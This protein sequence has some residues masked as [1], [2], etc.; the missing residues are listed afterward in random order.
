MPLLD[1]LTSWCGFLKCF[2]IQMTILRKKCLRKRMW[3]RVLNHMQPKTSM[4]M[5]KLL[6]HLTSL[7]P[8]SACEQP[9]LTVWFASPVCVR[10]LW[11]TAPRVGAEMLWSP[12]GEERGEARV[13]QYPVSQRSEHLRPG[14]RCR[15]RRPAIPGT[16]RWIWR[17]S[18]T[19]RGCWGCSSGKCSHCWTAYWLSWFAPSGTSV[20]QRTWLQKLTFSQMNDY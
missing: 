10:S 6:S 17:V 3:S 18:A 8:L 16:V 11:L 2:K 19:P 4:S 12:W 20:W 1:I 9:A 14:R 5:N 13:P 15:R 7:P